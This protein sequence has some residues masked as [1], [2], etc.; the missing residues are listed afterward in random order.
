MS[1]LSR[2]LIRAMKEFEGG[3]DWKDHISDKWDSF[4]TW[5]TPD[6]YYDVRNY[7]RN[8]ILFNKLAWGWKC[9]ESEYS[10]EVFRKLIIENGKA[11]K[12]G[13][14]KNGAKRYK[15]ACIMAH[16][17]KR[18]YSYNCTDDKGYMYI[19][20][21]YPC[22]ITSNGFYRGFEEGSI[23]DKMRNIAS[24]RVDGTEDKLKK[25][26]WEYVSKCIGEIWD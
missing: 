22:K 11:C 14:L 1:K 8:F 24:K 6:L 25:E 15:K 2:S 18:A 10:V 23:A 20:T 3:W 21:K 13:H 26:A 19:A 5:I 17:L 7:L 12:E 16:K 4:V 9:W